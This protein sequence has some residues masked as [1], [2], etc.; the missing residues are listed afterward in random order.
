M[1]IGC[2]EVALG[3]D[4]DEVFV[5]F[6]PLVCWSAVAVDA[7]GRTKSEGVSRQ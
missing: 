6:I 1:V 7:T 4:E 5:T 3:E 2:V